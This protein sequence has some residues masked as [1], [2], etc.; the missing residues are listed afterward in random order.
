MSELKPCPFCGKPPETMGSGAGR[1]GLMIE[2]INTEC[3][4]PHCSHYDHKAAI[5]EW[6]TRP[7]PSEAEVEAAAKR[8]LAADSRDVG[9]VDSYWDWLMPAG[10]ENY[11]R[12]ARAA[13]G[14]GE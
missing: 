8:I 4:G 9:G 14:V 12:M 7:A 5:E 13:L 10:R 3:L 6:N 11:L 1:R 2:C